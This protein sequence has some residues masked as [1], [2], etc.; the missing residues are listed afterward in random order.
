MKEHPNNPL[1]YWMFFPVNAGESIE[2]AWVRHFRNREDG[3][4][5]FDENSPAHKA[6]PILVVS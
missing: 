6:R 1:V 5:H 4:C 3:T 2:K